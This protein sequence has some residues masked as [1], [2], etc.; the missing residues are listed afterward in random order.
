MPYFLQGLGYVPFKL[1][2]VFQKLSLKRCYFCSL[3]K[4]VLHFVKFK[5][6][7]YILRTT[8]TLSATAELLTSLTLSL[9]RQHFHR[10]MSTETDALKLY[11]TVGWKHID[12]TVGE[13]IRLTRAAR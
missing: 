12:V 2:R 11:H 4:P 10:L 5:L 7:I 6:V 9:Q 8:C 1:S 13:L 3:K